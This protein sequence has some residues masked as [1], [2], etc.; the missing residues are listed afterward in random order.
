MSIQGQ[1]FYFNPPD[2][3]VKGAYGLRAD[4]LLSWLGSTASRYTQ[5]EGIRS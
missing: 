5:H 1:Y 4:F 2:A 3:A